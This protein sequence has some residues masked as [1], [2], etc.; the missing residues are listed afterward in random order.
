M[1]GVRVKP[2]SEARLIYTS[3]LIATYALNGIEGT[4]VLLHHFFR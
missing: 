1:I 4:Q 2:I 3:R